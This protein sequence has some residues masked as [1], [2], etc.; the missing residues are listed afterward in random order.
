MV[1]NSESNFIYQISKNYNVSKKTIERLFNQFVGISPKKYDEIL[2]INRAIEFLRRGKSLLDITF[3]TG[4]YDQAHFIKS[5]KKYTGH[6]PTEF[7]KLL[8]LCEMSHFYNE[9]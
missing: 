8:N 4:F 3:E 1:K 7:K 2:K 9:E 5:L 6:T